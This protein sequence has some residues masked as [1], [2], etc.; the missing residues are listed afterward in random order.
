MI[1]PNPSNIIR[2]V[3]FDPATRR[4]II[5][6]K[7][8]EHLYRAPQYMTI[9][10]YQ[11]YENQQ[12]KYD[13][14]KGISSA[15]VDSTKQQ[16]GLI[17]SFSVN[18]PLFNTIFGGTNIDIRAQGSA[19]I[20]LSGKINKNE[21]PLLTERQRQQFNLDFDQR[22]QMNVTGQ[23]GTRFRMATN[24]NT[25]SQFDFENEIKL[26]LKGK[27]DD[28]I[29]KIEIG[30]VSMPLSSSLI[31][32]SQALF[33]LK[34]QLQFGPLSVTSVFSQQ[35]SQQSEITITNGSQQNEFRISADSYETNK[36][37]FLAHYFRN[38][39]NEALQSIPIIRSSVNITKVE[40]WITNRTNSATDSR[41]V[42]A[43]MD[44]GENAPYQT[45]LFQGGGGYSQLPAGG[46]IND[47]A[48]PQQSNNLLQ[49][50]P[51]DALLTNSN[52]INAYFQ[53]YG[54]TD[55][56]SKLTYARKLTDQEYVLNSRLGYISL[57]FAL[58]ADEVLAVAY[59]YNSNGVEYQVGQLSSDVPVDPNAP[60]TL[61]T[62]L[63]KNENLKTSLPTWDLMMKNIYS[64]G[65]Y[66]VSRTD[67][68]L[69]VYRLDENS[70]VE[71]PQMSEGQN[72]AG[73]RWLQLTDLD[74]LNQAGDRGADGTFDF[75]D[76][77]TIDPLYGR[78]TFPL[79]EPFGAD[80]AAQFTP[81]EQSL[82]DKYAY[83][84]LYDS[85]RV[86]AQQLFPKLNRYIIKGTYQS[87]VS[88]EFQLNATNI[89]A[90]SVQVFAGTLPLA[91]GV[92]FTVDYNI[93]RVRI[94]N[95]ALL[96]SGQTIRIKLESNELFG[97]QQRSLFGSRL[98]YK[99]SDRFNIGGTIM[100]LT[101]KPLTAKVNIGEEPISNTMWGLDANYS[102]DSRWLTR[103]VDKIPFIDTK[104]L[105]SVTMSGEFANL[106]P[107]HPKSLDFAGSTN[108]VSY[109]DD[110]EGTRSIIDLKSAIGWQL[111]GTP[112]LFPES[113]LS[114]DRSYGYNRSRLAF[115][116]LDPIFFNR[117][118]STAPASIRSN[119][120]ELS[121]HYVREV[122]EQEVFPLKQSPTGLALTL[123]TF[124]L[125]FY[126]MLRGPYNYTTTGLN[127]NGQLLN[128][129]SR[130][131]GLFRKL[132]TTDFESLNVEFV[133]I[134]MM[135]PFIYK[136]NS[137]GGDLYLNLGNISEDI[138]KDGRK[139]LENGLPADGGES[140]T[141][142][143]QWGRV[144]KL[145]PIIQAFDNNP[146]VRKVQDVGLDGLGD[147]IEKQYFAPFVNQVSGQLT[148]SAAAEINADPSSDNYQYYR[149][150][151][152]EDTN[153]GILKRYE[154]YNGTEGNSKTIAQSLSETGIENSAATS[155]PDGEDINRDNNMSL[156]DEY[157]QYKISI[158]PQDM[159]VGQNFIADKVTST[160]KLANG[161]TQQVSWYQ[162][163]IPI[164]QYQQRVGNI[165]DFK[166][167]RFMRM[168]M[169]DFADSSVLRL[170]KL[171]L[172]R[173]EW[174]RYNSESSPAKVLVDPT[175]GTN[176]GLDNS[177]L[178]VSTINIEENGK[179]SPI[180]Y[181]VP[182]G[183][184]RERDLTNYTGDTQQNEQ[185]LLVNVKNLR[186]GYTR[187]AF[188]TGYNDFRSYGRLEMFI[189]AE[190]DLLQDNEISAVVRI[191]TDNQ[192][193]YY[194]YEIPLQITP[195]GT[196]DPYSIW[197]E[198]NAMDLDLK[199]LQ[200]AKAERN[201][202]LL[203]GLPW[204]VNVPYVY[205]D[206]LN[207]IRVMGQP[208]LSKVRVYMVGIKNPLRTSTRPGGDDGLEKSGQV[209][210]NELRLTDF[211]ER[212]G[213]AATARMNAKLADFADV[214]VSGSKSTVGFGSIDQ[215]TSERNRNDDKSV[216]VAANVELGKFFPAKSGI[217]IPVFVQV[218]TQN[219]TP[220]YDPRSSDLELKT[221]LKNLSKAKQD[222]IHRIVD[223]YTQRRSFNLT[224]VRKIKTDP[225]SKSRI[226]DVENLS[227]SYSFTDYSHRDYITEKSVQKTYRGSLAY[228]YNS[229]P[230]NYTPFAKIIKSNTFALLR[231][232]NFNLMPSVLNFRIDVDRLYT[233]NSLRDNDPGNVLPLST[234]NKNFQ[235]SRLYGISWNLT[236]SLQV[237]F[238]A[239]NY[240]I[241]DEPQGKVNGLARDTI[242]ENLKKLG[243][244][245]D[246]NH[247]MNVSYTLPVNKIPGF[248]WTN[249][250]ARYGT[251]FSWKT[252]PLITLRD[253]AIDYGNTI[254]N[255]RIIQINPTLN[256]V[257]L[258][259][260][261]DFVRKASRD[262]GS[263]S[264]F[265]VGTVTS[266]KN[267]TGA[268]TITN[269]TFMPG[270]LPGTNL[271]GYDL[272][273]NAPGWGFIF[274]SQQDI[275]GKAVEKGWI[276]RD[277][278]LNQLYVTSRK[279][280]INLRGTIEPI[281]DLRIELI[282][283]KSS[284]FNY[285]TNFRFN[286]VTNEFENQS[287]V[288]SGDFSISFIALRTAFGKNASSGNTNLFRKFE[289]NRSLIS[290]RLAAGNPN[291]NGVTD[292]Y[293]DGYGKNSQ[294]VVVASFIA[295]YTGQ[296]VSSVSLKRFPGIPIPNWR[297][298]YNGLT[299]YDFFSNMF[300]SFNLNHSYRSTYNVN[301][302]NS[303][304]R[305]AEV[306]GAVSV[307]DAQGNFLPYYQFTQVTLFEQFVPLIGVDFRLKNNVS[308]NCEYRQTRGLS[309]S[310][311]NSQLAQ[312]EEKGFVMGMGYRSANFRFPF[313]LFAS[314]KS[315]NDVNLKM[316][317][318][319]NDIKTVIYR[320]DVE[321]AEV[322]SG[323]KT[324]SIK[325]SLDYILNQR[326]NVR[327]FYDGSVNKPYTSQ[328]FN[329]SFSNFGIN[330]KFTIQ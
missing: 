118:G 265:L 222:S 264:S 206:G 64:L 270:Y 109:V 242:W 209:W 105:S 87:E 322:S 304:V 151:S 317:V 275:R 20:T 146:E 271:L 158:R 155:L 60:K 135:D 221:V 233:E 175:L 80:L 200:A 291:S 290:S 39:Y 246:Y 272:D 35:K 162:F 120:D 303:L 150:G 67:F 130:W 57:N 100:N 2:T 149:G 293:A 18:S 172:A 279:E 196:G 86:I 325:P 177:V 92:D 69:N 240:S 224:N 36:H 244:T 78:I 98:D 95:Q 190:G 161:S 81:A 276:T 68:N 313:G 306:D 54:G 266:I 29:Q 8:G 141:D 138:L 212:G 115:Y 285:S 178:D 45:G 90:G 268:Y 73:Q 226:W 167:I 99:V 31:T 41:D 24:Y 202:A 102:S 280:D 214:T 288:T 15:K 258:Y 251:N 217:Q 124:D 330:L 250:I 145:Q 13:F 281:K 43:F 198:S 38:R 326:L 25:E 234:F 314:R 194:E 238:N 17:P 294:D 189:H 248:S 121:N 77:V 205:T 274:G 56:Y 220:Q 66:Q 143:T 113:T 61:V 289:A 328:T 320:A 63:L 88:S 261:F 21:N 16:G 50:L 297:I 182:P 230:R 315:K 14:W 76:G 7:I 58:N 157:Y 140:R 70:G 188:K 52:G 245:T 154:K 12:L 307:K 166:S 252:E 277:T 74:N 203:D 319:I 119:K 171:Q 26:D 30:N 65:A 137:E 27:P 173:G 139:S 165:E 51:Q 72:T 108:G 192:D 23:I 308:L 223:D 128:P 46:P 131:G 241:I 37:Y 127:Q 164:S 96:N 267:L 186:D 180:P 181:V 312:Q 292:G 152:L 269:G 228:N 82:K 243:R 6:E 253:P 327:L 286:Q 219:S 227:A 71:K 216:D 211:D 247:T 273:E 257:G 300:S 278:L 4:Y 97:L 305:Y 298:S 53:Q 42:L 116:N 201:S 101:E 40:V 207:T 34:T 316:D 256:F 169:T 142:S 103:M 48:F 160:V 299:K 324:I 287:P 311:T 114:N 309:L 260:K 125:A 195:A 185:S 170:A 282:A 111:S 122:Y 83:Q 284:N 329:T 204:P 55:N 295:A 176:P 262:K 134:W 318:A 163:K 93:G 208:D 22:I 187:A 106:I 126:P 323:A 156:T 47:P 235:M 19:D 144:P 129:K 255:S 197:P 283:L 28:I 84:P 11:R 32:G 33:G 159:V 79:V 132:E 229:K 193:N 179:R 184:N 259:N 302:F 49:N 232:F 91:E 117:A 174:R 183:I 301:G 147:G 321:D 215:R 10:D 107:G 3:E 5:Q 218:S 225:T 210:F 89:P 254:Q 310:L 110:F 9:D 94:L 191:G 133:E 153:A 296:D 263:L 112:Q 136:P 59:R 249:V 75:V 44:L 237:D 213:W 1:L 123:P 104:V 85:T 148:S 168:F 231:D 199:N 62:K 236:K 239:T